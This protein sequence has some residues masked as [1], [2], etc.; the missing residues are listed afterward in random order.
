MIK[1]PFDC[2]TG[3]VDPK[4]GSLLTAY[5]CIL[6]DKDEII[7]ELDLKLKPD[8]G[9][10]LYEQEAL[11]V[12][13]INI[14]EHDKVAITYSEGKQRLLSFLKKHSPKKRGIRPCGH[15]IPFDINFITSH[16]LAQEEWDKY[17][18]YRILDTTPIATFLQDIGFL[19]PKI[20]SLTS[21]VEHF[22]VDK[23]TAH[24]AKGDVLMWI[25]VYKKMSQVFKNLA[26]K[27][28]NGD[29][30]TVDNELSILEL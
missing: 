9:V 16:L 3:S 23:K 1:M 17:C 21:L 14:D 8:D 7:D 2:E 5:F 29:I 18:H 11:D 12:N 20:G 24:E 19:P 25:D 30:N 6:N 22:Q 28:G 26:L 13:G 27:S 15:N 10:Y 4:K